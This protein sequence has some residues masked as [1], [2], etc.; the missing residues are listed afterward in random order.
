MARPRSDIEPRIV[1]AAR[2]RFLED[3]VDGASLRRIARD[4][5]TSI[6]M[7]YYYFPT[8][9]DLFLGVVEETYAKLLADMTLALSPDAPVRERIRRLY[10]RVGAVSDDELA[11]VKLVAREVLVSSSRFD[12]L[13]GRFQR[14]HFPLVFATLAEGVDDGSLRGD[15][16]PALLFF[17]TLAVG[18]LPQLLQRAIGKRPP[19]GALPD[20]NVLADQ[21]V[22]VLFDGVGS[23]HPKK[24]TMTMP[25][26]PRR[27]NL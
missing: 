4:A 14:G 3:G 12:R 19:F 23:G 16:P 25:S 18:A 20:S 15:L 5:R 17:C 27:R 13:L 2:R 24:R 21:L 7:V 1:R 22:G 26:A 8:K 6:G 11:T 10:A 9:D